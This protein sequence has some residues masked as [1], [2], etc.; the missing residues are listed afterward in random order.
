[1][2]RRRFLAGVATCAAIALPLACAPKQEVP[3][4]EEDMP[5][6]EDME[7]AMKEAEEETEAK[8]GQ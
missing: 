3:E 1:M 2:D 4:S 8:S 5:T 7:N 6:K